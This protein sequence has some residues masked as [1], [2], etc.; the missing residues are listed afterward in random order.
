MC[1][2]THNNTKKLV[3]HLWTLWGHTCIG[4]HV[5]KCPWV[6]FCH[7]LHPIYPV[8]REIWVYHLISQFYMICILKIQKAHSKR[9]FSTQKNGLQQFEKSL[10]NDQKG[11]NCRRTARWCKIWNFRK[12]DFVVI[13]IFLVTP[14]KSA[15]HPNVFFRLSETKVVN[16]SIANA[17]INFWID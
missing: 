11:N 1:V 10:L 17:E 6:L 16:V 15:Y 3:A 5:S 2:K 14:S 9:Y 12:R 8:W 7:E 13:S 4:F